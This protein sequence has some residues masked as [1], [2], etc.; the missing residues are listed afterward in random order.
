MNEPSMRNLPAPD[1]EP[2]TTPVEEDH[3]FINDEPFKQCCCKC[4]FHLRAMYPCTPENHAAK[5]CFTQ[6]GWAC[7]APIAEGD[8]VINWPMHSVGCEMFTPEYKTPE[9]SEEA[10][11]AVQGS[12]EETGS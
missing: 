1:N 12:R 7:G 4:K 5:I 2:I 3:C 11:N 8:V 9:K 10:I 6:Q